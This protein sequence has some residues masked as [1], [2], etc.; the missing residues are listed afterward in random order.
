MTATTMPELSAARGPELLAGWV[1]AVLAVAAHYHLDTSRERIRGAAAWSDHEDIGER[2]RQ[3]ARQAGLTVRQV[4]P[5]L[6]TLSP[7]RLPWC[8]SCATGRWPWSPPSRR[9]ACA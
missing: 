2:V 6:D 4:A 8:C 3:M 1:D 5:R 7:W 9:R